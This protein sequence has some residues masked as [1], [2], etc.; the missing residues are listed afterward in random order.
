[1]DLFRLYELEPAGIGIS[2]QRL[3]PG[4]G[5]DLVGDD[6]VFRELKFHSGDAPAEIRLT[7]H[8]YQ[9]AG[10]DGER[11]ELVV[12]EHVWD[13]P[14]ITM[15]RNPLKHLSYTPVGGVMVQ[16]W[17]EQPSQPPLILQRQR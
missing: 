8:E 2:D 14:T 9:R 6:G 7:E 13:E 1:M 4:V 17:R 11:Y 12:V 16:G 15:V 10:S 3:H 5:A